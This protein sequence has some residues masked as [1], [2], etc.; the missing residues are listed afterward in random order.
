MAN[1]QEVYQWWINKGYP[2]H[3][4]AALTGN[5]VAES[6]LDPTVY[7]KQGSGAFGTAQWLGSRKKDLLNFAKSEGKD[8]YDT[9]TQ[10]EF[11]DFELHGK[12]ANALKKLQATNNV[13][14]AAYAVAKYYERPSDKEI[15]GSIAKRT[16]VA[17]SLLGSEGEGG[18][19]GAGG[20]S[21]ELSEDK[22]QRIQAYRKAKESNPSLTVADFKATSPLYS[23]E[24]PTTGEPTIDEAKVAKILAYRAAK[25]QN[26]NLTTAEFKAT[27][28]LYNKPL[29]V[30]DNTKTEAASPLLD[31]ITDVP[32]LATNTAG[33]IANSATKAVGN[34]LDT[35][36]NTP[37]NISNLMGAGLGFIGGELGVP[38]KFLP[39]LNTPTA[40]VSN[41]AKETGVISSNPEYNPT[42][43]GGKVA[44]AAIQGGVGYATL[45]A[46]GLANV[47]KN[48]LTGATMGGTASAVTE[49]TDNPLVGTV[50]GVVAP[51]VITK[52][53][54]LVTNNPLTRGV[55]KITT[56][57]ANEVPYYSKAGAEKAAAVRI[58][59][60]FNTLQGLRNRTILSPEDNYGVI[61]L[62]AEQRLALSD[63]LKSK[64]LKA[65]DTIIHRNPEL[66]SSS[67]GAALG[68]ALVG[69][70]L[71][72]A[73]AG[74]FFKGAA[75]K[76]VDSLTTKQN[77]ALQDAVNKGL[78]NPETLQAAF[79]KMQPKEVPSFF[80]ELEKLNTPESQARIGMALPNEDKDKKPVNKLISN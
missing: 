20:L 48:L 41:L 47:G 45:P 55:G 62:L 70:P 23:V 6:G 59:E 34:T 27:S 1:K 31:T 60:E 13:E 51:A 12:E 75:K 56:K 53:S 64:M 16:N 49:A 71:G 78:T 3:E 63:S 24:K 77:Q 22:V 36:V 5:F 29:T 11:A 73:V 2:P 57:I 46:S 40:K 17:Q 39:E 8:P 43:T 76:L 79:S 58:N 30:T 21:T 50:A 25:S 52:G 10:L 38:A 66:V 4:A 69:S 61:K 72:G 32:R 67:A 35:I 18:S 65:P 42:S 28:P 68:S 37:E 14:D 74:Y 33:F 15:A 7:N 9:A 44:D 54:S 26:P 19:G 80:K